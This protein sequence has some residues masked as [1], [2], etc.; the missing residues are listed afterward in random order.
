[1]ALNTYLEGSR[2]RTHYGS[3]RNPRTKMTRFE[4][5]EQRALVGRGSHMPLDT[6]IHWNWRNP[7]NIIP[8]SLLVVLLIAVVGV[9]ASL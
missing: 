5:V 8:A 6:E 9:I 4:R 2:P 3:P 1:M 7:L